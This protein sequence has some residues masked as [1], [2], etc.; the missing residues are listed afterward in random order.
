LKF[1]ICGFM[2][3]GKTSY[4]QN[5]SKSIYNSQM[6]FDCVDLDQFIYKELANN[7]SSLSE[8]I[9]NEGW[10]IF[11]ELEYKKLEFLLTRDTTNHQIIALGGGVLENKKVRALLQNKSTILIY[12]KSDFNILWDRIKDCK[13]RPLVKQGKDKIYQ[14]FVNREPEYLKADFTVGSYQEFEEIINNA[15][16]KY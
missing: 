2:G 12:L 14:K 9:E 3:A 15:S 6:T 1:L 8:F 16:H 10:E 5:F 7:Y 13:D 11:R 4:L